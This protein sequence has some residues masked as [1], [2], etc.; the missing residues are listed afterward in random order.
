MSIKTIIKNAL[1]LCCITL[2][3]GLSL[4]FVHSITE[5]PIAKAQQAAT[6]AAYKKVFESAVSFQGIDEGTALTEEFNSQLDISLYPGVEIQ[7]MEKAVDESG[8]C[9]GVIVTAVSSKGYGGDIQLVIGVSSD[10]TLNGMSVLSMSESAGLGAK[11]TTAEFQD[12]FKGIKSGSI[13]YT[14]TGASA[15]NEIDTI[16]GATITTKAVTDAVNAGLEFANSYL[17]KLN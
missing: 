3:A 10:G 15:E 8:S 13:K 11:C 2:A 1:I 14:K 9:I 6:E 4:S 7:G 17:A 5:E 16:S 12:Q